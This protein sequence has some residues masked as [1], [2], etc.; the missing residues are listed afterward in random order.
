MDETTTRLDGNACAGLL[1]EIFVH[2]L[3][4][5]RGACAGC[6]AIAEL[7]GQ[8]LYGYPHGPGAVL[9]CSACESVLMVVVHLRGCYRLAAP[10]LSWIEVDEQG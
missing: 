8:H 7:G 4:A 10:G 1:R 3:T 6:G 9:R 5:A 2:D